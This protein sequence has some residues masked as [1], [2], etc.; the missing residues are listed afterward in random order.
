MHFGDTYFNEDIVLFKH[1]L[2]YDFAEIYL[3]NEKITQVKEYPLK[4]A[5]FCETLSRPGK[6]TRSTISSKGTSP[7]SKSFIIIFPITVPVFKLR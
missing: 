3:E 5:S 4:T 2:F 7:T 1:N 6:F